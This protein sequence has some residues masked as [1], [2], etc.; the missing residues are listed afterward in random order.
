[1]ADVRAAPDLESISRYMVYYYNT[2]SVPIEEFQGDG[3]VMHKVQW[4][5]KEGFRQKKKPRGD[6][7]WVRR[8][9]RAPENSGIGQVDGQIVGRL[10][11]LF[12]VQEDTVR[13][14]EMA[15]VILL[16]VCRPA[17][18]WEEEGII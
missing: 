2:L 7:V 4:T 1:M 6:W 5:G 9:E 11:E 17:R 16:R 3:D 12:S 15:L 8:Q 18:P 13:I 14:H 10:K